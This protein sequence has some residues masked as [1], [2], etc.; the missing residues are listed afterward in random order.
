MSIFTWLKRRLSLDEPD[1]EEE[2]R[3][4]LAMAEREHQEAGQPE[5]R[6]AARKDF[7][8]V[9]LTTAAA[10]EVWRPRWLESLHDW[11]DDVRYAVRALAKKPGFTLT[12]TGVLTLGIGLN[13]AV[14]T[15]LKSMALNPLAGVP[16]AARLHVLHGETQTGREV[17]VSYPD[18]RQL[19]DQN[20][21]FL[22]LMGTAPFRAS[23]GRGRDAHRVFGEMVTGNYFEVLG[24]G[25]QRGRTLL[26]S[27]EGAPG[28]NPVVVI[29]D[30]LWRRD[31]GADPNITGR[32]LL[33]NNIPLTI[34]GVASASFHGTVVSYDIE[35]YLP[36]TMAGQV[37]FADKTDASQ[38]LTDERA[39]LLY[40]HGY[41]R[42][43]V[44]AASAGAQAQALFAQ[45]TRGRPRDEGAQML[46]LVPLW[47]SPNGAQTFL[48]PTLAVL[49]AMGLLVL[50]ISCANIAGLVLVRGMSRRGEIAVRLALG[51][52]RARVMR[53]LVLENLAVSIPG[54]LLGVVLAARGVPILSGYAEW[55]AAP[56]RLFFNI[57]VDLF[58]IGFAALLAACSALVFGLVPA[59]Q[60]SHINLVTVINED[61]S[62]RGAARGSLRKGLVIAQVAI[63]VAL[64]VSS[65]LVSRSLDAARRADPGFVQDHLGAVALDLKANAYDTAR[66]LV[67]YRELLRAARTGSGVESA[68][69]SVHVPLRLIETPSQAV[70]VEGYVPRRDEELAMLWNTIAPGYFHTLQTKVLAGREFEDRDDAEAEPRML[71][72]Q[73]FAQRFWGGADQALGKRVHTGKEWR[74]IIGVVADLKYSRI[75]EAARPYFYLPL[76]QAYR[77][78]VVLQLRGAQPMKTLLEQARAS[79]ARL[80]PDL[81]IVYARPMAEM[82]GGA[83]LFLDLTAAMLSLFGT[84]GMMLAALGTYGLV[85]YSVTASAR[86]TGIR[87]ALGASGAMVLR[88]FLGNGLRLGL[89]GAALGILGAFGAIQLLGHLLYGVSST[90][91]A[92][93]AKALVIVIGGVALA[94]LVPAWRATRTSP[95]HALRHQ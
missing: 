62:T 65:G 86:E 46:K 5:A 29:S 38:V 18:Y 45:L 34:V 51:A 30:S 67:F 88:G 87:M 50:L 74:T 73:T 61:S 93:F 82:T 68:T 55:L 89:T 49:A 48:L 1:F 26:P 43:G 28:A 20:Q 39:E 71:V 12:V 16:T 92:S 81:P 4:H 23:L 57:E 17:S 7:G 83:T 36:V 24:V 9:T 80:D 58:I 25:A 11:A 15:M 91:A 64:L 66:G 85:S 90:D 78:S 6:H 59:W 31:Y 2:I 35:V 70:K 3:S 69:L 27:D 52:G 37:G 22:S 84:A 41:L 40:P 95:Q 42:P 54:A 60:T 56:D 72:N 13:S 33:V 47:K 8:N 63:S 79:V 75:D 77:P 44:T 10:R 14:F 21:A 32:I 19:R 53:L 94:T 76:W